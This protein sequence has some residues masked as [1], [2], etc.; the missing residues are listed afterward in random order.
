MKSPMGEKPPNQAHTS[1]GKAKAKKAT[2]RSTM[3]LGKV[4]PKAS[5]AM[6]K[7]QRTGSG[8]GN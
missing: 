4:G 6:G 3:G 1:A 2:A 7:F 8:E 5:G